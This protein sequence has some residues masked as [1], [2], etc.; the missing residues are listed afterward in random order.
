MMNKYYVT[1]GQK[2][3]YEAHPVLGLVPDLPD[4]VLVLWAK[5]YESA[6][7]KVFKFLGSSFAFIYDEKELKSKHYPKGEFSIPEADFMATRHRVKTAAKM[8]RELNA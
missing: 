1:F 4:K 3:R 6:R 5:D 8:K 2:Y 7:A